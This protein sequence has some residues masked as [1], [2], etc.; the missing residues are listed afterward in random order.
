MPELPEVETVCRGIAPHIEGGA[1]TRVQQNRPNLRYPF[2][3]DFVRTLEGLSVRSVNRRS[4]Y[5]MIHLS[6]DKC[7][8]LHLGMSGSV[9][10]VQADDLYCAKKHDHFVLEF[11]DGVRLVYNDPRRF[12]FVLLLD[13]DDVKQDSHF[14][15]LGPEP[16]SNGFYADYLYHRICNSR[17]SIKSLL[18]NQKVV[19]GL[20]NIYV[21]EVL[22][23]CGIHP[24]TLGMRISERD[25]DNLVP[26]IR[27]VLEEA[28][29]AGGS[30]LRDYKQVDGDLG[31]FQHC[32]QVYGREGGVCG[33]D[34]C[35]CVDLGGVKRIVQ[36]G[37][38]SFFCPVKQKEMT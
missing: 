30:T 27:S 12:G 28:I 37:R 2:P 35:G 25:C 22:Y 18:L 19:A 10:I 16:L 11:S 36:S 6:R 21:C 1:I 17:S 24:S 20:G 13:E 3:D 14:K 9:K 33:D 23:S 15:A 8:V 5:V 31:Y 34:R 7:M 32:F 26:A 4:K 38:S 29:K